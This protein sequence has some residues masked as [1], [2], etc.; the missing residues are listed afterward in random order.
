MVNERARRDTK[1]GNE[2][3]QT[4]PKLESSETQQGRRGRR[5]AHWLGRSG[6]REDHHQQQDGSHPVKNR[7]DAEGDE[8]MTLRA[9]KS[10]HT[11]KRHTGYTVQ[12][13]VRALLVGKSATGLA[14][15]TIMPSLF[16]PGARVMMSHLHVTGCDAIWAQPC[17]KRG[18]TVISDP[19]PQVQPRSR[20][21]LHRRAHRLSTP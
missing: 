2:G 4:K 5:N 6:D 10:Q 8:R 21:S 18:L 19:C 13:S 15:R 16:L 3:R 17:S 14:E 7:G 11:V 20:S 1:P 9:R 12:R